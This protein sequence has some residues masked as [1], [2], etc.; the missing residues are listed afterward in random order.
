MTLLEDLQRITDEEKEKDA[1]FKYHIHVC[2]AAGCLSSQSDV[3]KKTLQEEVNKCGWGEE[4]KVKGVGC[5]GG[6]RGRG[7]G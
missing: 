4:C 1:K 3:I 7:E 5:R 6:G 2:V